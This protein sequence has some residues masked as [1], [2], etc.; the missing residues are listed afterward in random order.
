MTK[1]FTTKGD[2]SESGLTDN[3]DEFSVEQCQALMQWLD[4]YKSH[5]T[6]SFV[7][8]PQINKKKSFLE[9]TKHVVYRIK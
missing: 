3:I 7:G 4:F 8:K 2:F 1:H 6:Y 5:K 9:Y